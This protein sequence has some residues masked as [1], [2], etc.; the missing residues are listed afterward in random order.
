M[1][2]ANHFELLFHKLN[3]DRKDQ[4]LY[5]DIEISVRD[6]IFPAHRC[7]LGAFSGYF[8]TLFS[9]QFRDKN[10]KRVTLSGPLGE[11]ISPHTFQIVLDFCY[12]KTLMIRHERN[13]YY[14][15]LAAATFLQI[16]SLS[17]ECCLFLYNEFC[18]IGVSSPENWLQ[19]Y[20][21]A[22]KFNQETLLQSCIRDFIEMEQKIDLTK[23]ALHDLAYIVKHGQK[24][25]GS[26]RVFAIVLEWVESCCDDMKQA[27]FDKLVEHVD[28]SLMSTYY[29]AKHVSHNNL[30]MNSAVALQSL[31]R[32]NVSQLESFDND[33][34]VLLS[35]CSMHVFSQKVIHKCSDPPKPCVDGS[36]VASNS[37]HL[38][39]VGGEGKNDGFIQ[40]YDKQC[41]KWTVVDDP[42]GEGKYSATAT[43][44]D[45][46][47]YVTGGQTCLGMAR[48]STEAYNVKEGRCSSY[49]GLLDY[50]MPGLNQ[51]RYYHASVT[52]DKTTYFL[53]GCGF[54]VYQQPILSSCESIDFSTGELGSIA[55]MQRPN[56]QMAAVLFEDHILVMG[57]WDSKVSRSSV[58]CY[59]FTTDQWTNMQPMA[60][61]RFN[62]C[63][64]IYKN[65]V[66]VFGGNR[67]DSIEVHDAVNKRWVL[68]EFPSSIP[69]QCDHAVPW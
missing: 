15:V 31:A 36:V 67:C 34:I 55:P 51:P 62:H 19:C 32:A 9:C 63:A 27:Y 22:V 20:S 39:V 54:G 42:Y 65:K 66:Y 41:D 57:G 24:A 4:K 69:Q 10:D 14:N 40:V 12:T 37:T 21:I 1:E 16:T 60:V 45:D 68:E 3:E 18:T 59:S 8:S 25:L 28:F 49:M 6:V 11:D 17:E 29:V 48:R 64:S 53:G 7:V 30:V 58:E 2:P 5:C 38:F 44:I 23:F 43:I 61:P 13:G 26:S 47:M 56:H 46:I 33:G 35:E 50:E 52:K